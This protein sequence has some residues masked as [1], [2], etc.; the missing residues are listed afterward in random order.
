MV[1][2]FVDLKYSM[3]SEICH[4][5]SHA[6]CQDAWAVTSSL[7]RTMMQDPSGHR[8]ARDKFAVT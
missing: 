5:F 3:A 7:S 4:K 6:T 2:F 1:M 8:C